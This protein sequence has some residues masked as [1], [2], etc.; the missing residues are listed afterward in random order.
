VRLTVSDNGVGIPPG[1]RRSGLRNMSER[2]RQLGGELE[3]SRPEG[4]GA[5]IEW[6]VPL[7]ER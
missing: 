2:A 6:W 1:G 7:P 5:T 4:G 3:V